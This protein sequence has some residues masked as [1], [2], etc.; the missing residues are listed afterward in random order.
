MIANP[1][2]RHDRHARPARRS[3]GREQP[4][5]PADAVRQRSDRRSDGRG[6]LSARRRLRRGVG[7][8]ARAAAAPA[9]S[10]P[11]GRFATRPASRAI[12]TR[13]PGSTQELDGLRRARRS[14]QGRVLTLTNT[15]DATRRSSVFGYVEWCLGPPRAGRPPLRR[16]RASTRRPAR[17]W[18][19]TPTT[20]SS[21]AASAFWHVDASRRASFTCDRGEFVGRHRIAGRPAALLREQLA[22]RHRRGARSL[23][24]AAGADARSRRARS[25]RVAF[26]LGQGS[27][28]GH[29][30]DAGARDIRR[31]TQA[32]RRS[33]ESERT[34]DETLG[35]VQVHTPDDSFDLIVNR[36]LLYQ[37][38]SCRIW[39]RSGPYQPGGA[40]GFRDQLQDVLAL[41]YTRP[42][43]CREHLLR[44]ASRQ[45]V[46]GDV[47]HWWHPPSG[48]G[49]RTRCSDD[50]LWLPYAVGGV[51][52]ADRRRVGARRGRRRF[53]RRRCSSPI[54]TRST[55]CR[56]CRPRRASLFEH[57]V[58][59]INHALKYGAHG[60]PLIGS[61]DWN[62]GMNRVG[63]EGRGESVWLGW[64][65]VVVLNEFAPICERRGRSRSGGALPQRGALAHGHARAR[66]GRRLVSPRVFRR[67]HAARDRRRT[68]SAGSIR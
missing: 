2:V 5:E 51:R 62:D 47:Q 15:S 38:L 58:R 60:L 33:T 31:S 35:A 37:T 14:G 12:S 45:F 8:D 46:E 19:A 10:G 24:G 64:F 17:S 54:S 52:L 44:A 67:R 13:S 30:L 29:A 11:L 56:G 65:L 3:R 26:V 66:L 18:P 63:H 23:R 21:A 34:W 55:S 22:G 25:R 41:L 9:R 6:D 20:P 36:W 53:S 32:R 49:T 43:L 48:R 16:H 42:D 50:L 7:R 39:A 59:A 57:A 40:F 1:D 28:R 61:G 4:R 27:D 68:T